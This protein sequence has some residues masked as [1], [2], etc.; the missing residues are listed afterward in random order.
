MSSVSQTSRNFSTPSGAKS[1][2]VRAFVAV[3]VPEPTASGLERFMETLRPLARLR[4]V[5]RAQF[6]ITLRFIG[7]QTRETIDRLKGALAPI[8]FQP[9]ELEF[10]YVGAFS[11]MGNPRVLWLGGR[12]GTDKLT[13]LAQSVNDALYAAGLPREERSFKPHLTLARGNGAPLSPALLKALEKVPSLSWRCDRF[14]LM[15]SQLTPH[16]PIYSEISLN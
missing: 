4:W 8:T 7:E 2:F 11:S 9:F 13:T 6:H 3:P 5:T 10:S 15:R 14:A 1:S 12:K 16:G